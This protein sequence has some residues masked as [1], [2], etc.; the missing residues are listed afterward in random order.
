MHL[1]LGKSIATRLSI[2]DTWVQVPTLPSGHRAPTSFLVKCGR[3]PEDLQDASQV[4]QCAPW[5]HPG[6]PGGD[7]SYPPQP[8]GHGA[9]PLSPR[10][11]KGPVAP[12][13]Q[14]KGPQQLSSRGANPI[15]SDT[16]CS[17]DHLG[18]GKGGL[19]F[20]SPFRGFW[21]PSVPVQ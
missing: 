19:P 14:Q 12:V 4:T 15:P 17:S 13:A 3:D 7:T 16:G 9:A 20:T 10:L 21:K 8:G 1:C 6:L 18:L 2:G 11:L 5:A